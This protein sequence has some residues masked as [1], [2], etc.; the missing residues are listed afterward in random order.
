MKKWIYLSLTLPSIVA[1]FYQAN[2]DTIGRYAEIIKSIPEATLK[3][4]PKSQAWAHSARTI[5]A[6][7]EESITETIISMHTLTTQKNM[8]LFC[9][10]QGQNITNDLIHKVLEQ[11]AT[12]L[13]KNEAQKN[14]SEV[15]IEK[16]TTN[17]PCRDNQF[18]SAQNELFAPKNYQMQSV[19]R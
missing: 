11:S 1:P 8:P 10:P 18:Q 7:A 17:Y 19:T 3:A 13:S 5:L 9:L 16:L 2:A 14:L 15:V 4:D 6:V 12:N